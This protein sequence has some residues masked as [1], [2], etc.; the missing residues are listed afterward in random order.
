MP[1]CR[2]TVWKKAAS[3]AM[4]PAEPP[5]PTTGSL[6]KPKLGT[7]SSSMSLAWSSLSSGC[8]MR[9]LLDGP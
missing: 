5:M 7:T 2:G 6:R 3:A 4:A 1:V 9:V 8:V